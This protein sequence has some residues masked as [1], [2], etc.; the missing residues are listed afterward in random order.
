MFV[1]ESSC[2]AL[3]Q[4]SFASYDVHTARIKQRIAA[5]GEDVL[6]TSGGL[7]LILSARK[8][9]AVN[10]VICAYIQPASMTILWFVTAALSSAIN[11]SARRAASSGCK[12]LLRACLLRTC[13]SY[14]RCN[15]L[16]LLA[17]GCNGTVHDTVHSHPFRTKLMCQSLRQSNYSRFARRIRNQAGSWNGYVILRMLMTEPDW[18]ATKPGINACL[19]NNWC[20]RL[21]E[22]P[23]SQSDKVMSSVGGRLSWAALL[24]RPCICGKL[25]KNILRDWLYRTFDVGDIAFIKYRSLGHIF[26]SESLA[27]LRS[28]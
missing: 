16:L 17:F 18:A 11:Q 8:E 10:Q 23:R 26:R 14:V 27:A 5:Q 12:S 2:R 4:E 6:S 9:H 15:D 25:G 20:R 3:P 19:K 21:T 13:S 22:I 1:Y 7:V 28:L 24:I